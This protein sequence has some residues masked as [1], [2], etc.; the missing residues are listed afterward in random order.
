MLAQVIENLFPF[1]FIFTNRSIGLLF[2]SVWI[3]LII[4]VGV[5]STWDFYKNKYS[6]CIEQLENTNS[7]LSDLIDSKPELEEIKLTDYKVRVLNEQDGTSAKVRVLIESSDGVDS[8]STIGVSENI[9]EATWQALR[10]SLN[11]RLMKTEMNQKVSINK[12][13]EIHAEPL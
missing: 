9:I 6:D 11:Y 3:L 4:S 12:K 10:D 8:W 1:L 7:V 2:S 5:Y 13:E